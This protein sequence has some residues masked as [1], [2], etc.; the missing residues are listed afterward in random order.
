MDDKEQEVRF[1]F[2]DPNAAQFVYRPPSNAEMKAMKATMGVKFA[3]RSFILDD[4]WLLGGTR[5]TRTLF[6]LKHPI[7]YSKRGI[8]GLYRKIKRIF[9]KPKTIQPLA[10]HP[11]DKRLK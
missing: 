4:W 6:R 11:H 1:L 8:R 7:V 5:W 10:R 9:V 3:Q 2:P